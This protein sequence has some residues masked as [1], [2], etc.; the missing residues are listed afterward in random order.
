MSNKEASKQKH[1]Q[2]SNKK[3]GK[4]AKGQQSSHPFASVRLPGASPLRHPLQ[5][6]GEGNGPDGR[7]WGQSHGSKAQLPVTRTAEIR[8]LGI[9]SLCVFWG[10]QRKRDLEGGL[11][12]TAETSH[13]GN[14]C[15]SNH[16][17]L[18]PWFSGP[19]THSGHTAP[20]S[21]RMARHGSLLRR[22]PVHRPLINR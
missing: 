7:T 13:G 11:Q 1:K 4:Q 20:F 18:G 21:N 10:A 14:E 12:C 8:L 5:A 3:T 6:P 22:A 9:H 15:G 17:G 19:L 2:A 16:P